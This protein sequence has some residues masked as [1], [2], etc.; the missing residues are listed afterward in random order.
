MNTIL[1]NLNIYLTITIS[2][3]V[4]ITYVLAKLK[5]RLKGRLLVTIGS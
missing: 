1:R 3:P 2:R 4:T 5:K